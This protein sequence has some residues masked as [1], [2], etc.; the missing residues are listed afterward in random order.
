MIAQLTSRVSMAMG[1]TLTAATP[2][3]AQDPRPAPAVIARAVDSLASRIVS[4][5]VSP[6]IG[7]AV[8]MD[9]KTILAKAYGWADASAQI[10]ATDRT[11]WYVASTS[12]SYTGFAVSLLAHQRVIDLAAPITTLLPDVRWPAGVDATRL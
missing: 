1:L 2:L 6:A 7:V 5:G 10:P 12:K 3:G 9:G 8:V 11:L 4:S